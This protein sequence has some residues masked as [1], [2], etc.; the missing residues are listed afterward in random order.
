MGFFA[1]SDSCAKASALRSI[2]RQNRP[3]D[4]EKIVKSP[5]HRRGVTIVSCRD[6][7][8]LQDTA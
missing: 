4:E 6:F 7:F 3:K 5:R 8:D 1:S 2:I